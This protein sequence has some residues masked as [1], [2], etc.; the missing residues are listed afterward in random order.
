MRLSIDGL[1]DP[2][3]T[4][5]QS[6]D[7]INLGVSRERDYQ[8]LLTKL[9]VEKMLLITWGKAVGIYTLTDQQREHQITRSCRKKLLKPNIRKEVLNILNRIQH[10]FTD[11]HTLVNRYGLEQEI[12]SVTHQKFL[13][14]V[15]ISDQR[16][17]GNIRWNLE[18]KSQL[19]LLASDLNELNNN[20]LDLIPDRK[21]HVQ[22][23]VEGEVDSLNDV[24]NLKLVEDAAREIHADICGM[25]IIRRVLMENGQL[26]P[27]S[28]EAHVTCPSILSQYFFEISFR[29]TVKAM[30]P[31]SVNSQLQGTDNELPNNQIQDTEKESN[32]Q[33]K[34]IEDGSSNGQRQEAADE[35]QNSVSHS[36]E[37]AV[38][39]YVAVSP[40]TATLISEQEF[41][42]EEYQYG[43]RLAPIIAALKA[44]DGHR[45]IHDPP[46]SPDYHVR[47]RSGIWHN[48][49]HGRRLVT[50]LKAAR[51]V[52][53]IQL[54]NW[55]KC[56]ADFT[57]DSERTSTD[58]IGYITPVDT[59]IVRSKIISG[60]K[61]EL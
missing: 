48:P 30:E 45:T 35:S 12:A 25:A 29:L 22:R 34:G 8:V 32:S 50:E 14:A 61:E 51:H 49:A 24:D 56:I 37:P 3:S 33:G 19:G 15:S 46:D 28:G 1:I 27:S 41:Y 57:R 16:F 52:S 43:Q 9:N 40:E 47:T 55:F 42:P 10:T 17:P 36:S 21:I 44:A 53:A 23:L 7:M 54:F 59:D 26:H 60:I 4:C 5:A 2:F 31:K 20:L 39:T 6:Y 18:N 58:N 13:Q 38:Q 11:P